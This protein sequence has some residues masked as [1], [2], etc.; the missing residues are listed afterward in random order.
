M[1]RMVREG[2]DAGALGFTTS[3]TYAHRTRDGVP[4]GTRFSSA[5]ELLALTGAM[6]ETRRRRRA[7]DLR[8]LP[9][10]RRRLRP[11][12]DGA[13]ADDGRDVGAAAVD[14]RAAGRAGARPLARDGRP[15]CADR[16]RRRARPCASRSRP[17][18]VGVLQGLEASI[19]PVAICPS[20]REIAGLPLAERVAALRDPERRAR[21]LDEH[22]SVTAG[23]DGLASTLFTSFDKLFPMTDPVDYEPA[24]SSQHRRPGRGAGRRRPSSRGARPTGRGRRPPAALHD[25]VQ[26]RPRQ[27]RR[28][29]RD[30]A[31]AVLGD[32]PVRR[33]RPLRGDQRRQLPDDG[34]VPV[35][36]AAGRRAR[37]PIELMVHHLTQRTARQVGWLDRGVL[38]AGA[39]RR[40]QRD[41]PRAAGRPPTAHRARPARPAAAGCSRTPAAT[42]AR[43][44][45]APSRR[46][47]TASTPASCPAAS[48]AARSPPRPERSTSP[49]PADCSPSARAP[50]PRSRRSSGQAADGVEGRLRQL[51]RCRP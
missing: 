28:R 7:D 25:A 8:R 41:R 31:V 21:I 10:P 46:S 33:R 34:V 49:G 19:N 24:P 6:G 27:P 5:D 9:Q 38:A 20:F 18:P 51:S 48:S 35:D 1:A 13:D 45:A 36:E 29:P 50:T 47:T 2:V 23:L 42:C 32:R 3:R 26:L 15:G 4:L 17:R 37:C 22:A 43:S 30:A 44:S 39:P 12:R 40:R 14:D 11:R 16:R